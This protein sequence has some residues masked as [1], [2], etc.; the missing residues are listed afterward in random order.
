[1]QCP[2]PLRSPTD[3]R[4]SSK[5][6]HYYRDHGHDTEECRHLKNQIED[7]IRKG[8]L[9]KYVDRDAPQGRR[10]RKEEAPQQ[11]EEQQPREED[12]ISFSE[13]DL[14]GVRL[15]HDDLVV[16][17]LLVESFT[18]KRVIVDSG[19]SAGILYKAFDQLRIPED[20]LKSVKTHLVGFVGEIVHPLGTIDLSVIVGSFPYQ[21]HVQMTFLVVDT[22]S[23]YDVIIGRP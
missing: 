6:C 19:S 5:Y 18:M 22:L 16:V 8:Y 9:R 17:T 21:T 15:P 3:K 14:E 10:E 7:L 20:Q 13:L 4:D 1:I 11:R 12:E 2:A 23:P